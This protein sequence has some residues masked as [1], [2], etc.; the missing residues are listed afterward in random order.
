MA[1]IKWNNI[2]GSNMNQ[3]LQLYQ[4]A[5]KTMYDRVKDFTGGLQDHLKTM[6]QGLN[7][8]YEWERQKNTDDYINQMMQADSLEAIQQ[9]KE[10]TTAEAL[11]NRYGD[12]VDMSKVNQARST[13]VNDVKQRADNLDALKDNTDAA[14]KLKAQVDQLMLEGRVTEAQQLLSQNAGVL[15]NKTVDALLLRGQER[16]FKDR[17]FGL[18]AQRVDLQREQNE[19]SRFN[20]QTNADRAKAE[21][22]K[23]ESE[24]QTL[25]EN[26][27]MAAQERATD[28]AKDEI[29]LTQ[30][31][32][33]DTKKHFKVIDTELN[34]V[35]S[36]VVSS[37]AKKQ[38]VQ[39]ALAENNFGVLTKLFPD[40]LAIQ[41]LAH[42]YDRIQSLRSRYQADMKKLGKDADSV[43]DIAE[44]SDYISKIKQKLSSSVS[45]KQEDTATSDANNAQQALQT[46][47]SNQHPNK[48]TDTYTNNTNGIQTSS[49]TSAEHIK[50]DQQQAEQQDTQTQPADDTDTQ[51]KDKVSKAEAQISE[52]SVTKNSNPIGK[53]TDKNLAE[54]EQVIQDA[55]KS[56]ED[57]ILQLPKSKEV[58]PMSGQDLVSE[59]NKVNIVNSDR[60]I[61]EK[62]DLVMA[63]EQE[64][65]QRQLKAKAA[66]NDPNHPDYPNK[67]ATD[68][69]EAQQKKNAAELKQVELT[70]ANE[71]QAT[72]RLNELQKLVAMSNAEV[73]DYFNKI[74]N[75]INSEDDFDTKKSLVEEQQV[76]RNTY[77]RIKKS[78]DD[79][80]NNFKASDKEPKPLPIDK[81]LE[82]HINNLAEMGIGNVKASYNSNLPSLIG[83][84]TDTPVGKL[85]LD[86]LN[87]VNDPKN[88]EVT[89]T[90]SYDGS[91]TILHATHKGLDL[92]K[93]DNAMQAINNS[94]DVKNHGLD[95][96]KNG[97]WYTLWTDGVNTNSGQKRMEEFL[98]IPDPNKRQL[99]AKLLLTLT[100]NTMKEMSKLNS[101]QDVKARDKLRTRWKNDADALKIMID[102]LSVEHMN[103]LVSLTEARD[104]KVRTLSTDQGKVAILNT[105]Y[106]KSDSITSI[107]EVI[108][109]DPMFGLFNKE[110][111]S[112]SLVPEHYANSIK[113]SRKTAEVMNN[114]SKLIKYAQGLSQAGNNQIDTSNMKS[115]YEYQAAQQRLKNKNQ[116]EFK[117]DE[118]KKQALDLSITEVE[119]QLK[120]ESIF[121]P[122]DSQ[123]KDNVANLKK[124]LQQLISIREM[125]NKSTKEK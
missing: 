66:L 20:A 22:A 71:V 31:F 57:L 60:K 111:G 49:T 79:Y 76:L 2:D 85:V 64:D 87:N 75:Q 23:L 67:L 96:E 26:R 58:V 42:S 27:S 21:I 13:W 100:D 98:Q 117:F 4:N 36:L 116:N 82:S 46:E 38:L 86:T 41:K 104:N 6:Q 3:G 47:A 88:P 73:I 106:A 69:E 11:R 52:T 83:T 84:T 125:A 78:Y 99:A 35:D 94:S 109:N 15:S 70:G 112:L 77:Q 56:Q 74:D 90:K 5:E 97:S 72:K 29:D 43:R 51:L 105:V 10:G 108:R 9:M 118:K 17:N 121:A 122:Y 28:I 1:E 113:T 39:Q 124:T 45:L 40:N 34:N 37:P 93:A 24:T 12:K 53:R 33:E 62:A 120:T 16:Y 50:P 107:K 30:K 101:A 123:N 32:T 68:M 110:S 7:N 91:T 102:N 48:H 119:A 92:S 55:A 61:E 14:I 95:H 89:V 65:K 115:I 80:V 8:Q 59:E 44:L 19:I 54:T 25:E 114:A 81:Y 18:E 103:T 63:Q